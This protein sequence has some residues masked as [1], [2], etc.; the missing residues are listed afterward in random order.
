MV[1][2]SK[3]RGSISTI[4]T[5]G[6]RLVGIVVR[7]RDSVNR[8]NKE[9]CYTLF[10]TTQN[11]STVDKMWV[12]RCSNGQIAGKS[13]AKTQVLMVTGQLADTPTRGLDISRTGQLVD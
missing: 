5:L 12:P 11:T 7:N 9:Y 2:A 13:V 1:R 4:A 10:N 3:V 8:S 6:S